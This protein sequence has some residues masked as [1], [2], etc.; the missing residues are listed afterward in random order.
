MSRDPGSDPVVADV[1]LDLADRR[2]GKVR[3]SY[4]LEGDRR[5]FITTDRLSAFDRIVAV[6]PW[7]GQ[8]L[9][10]LSAWWFNT[11][12]DIVDNHLLEVP[13]PRAMIVRSATPLPVEVVVR[14]AMT[15]ST[16]TSLWYQYSGGARQIYG[17][18]FPDGLIKNSLL[19]ELLITPTTKAPAGGHDEPLSTADVVDRG[20]V[21]A[22][23]WHRVTEAA[24]ALFT[25][26]EEIAARAGLILA[27]TKYEF[28]VD[29]EGHLLLIDEVHTPDSSRYW[30]RDTYL[31]RLHAGE[32]PE[33]LDKEPVRLALGAL[34]YRGEG[35]VPDLGAD[36]IASTSQRYIDAYERLTGEVFSPDGRDIEV[37]LAAVLD[38]SGGPR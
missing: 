29:S 2:E 28:G 20:L 37:R 22:D 17:Y 34:G 26:G 1:H 14:R 4:A 24:L 36:V 23:L 15:G 18:D 35:P 6:I 11:T 21:D 27:D 33:S 19:P 9:N 7:K 32:E 10:Q 12:R 16:T 31:D 25:R 13:D 30:A 3:V 8:V 38:P 5:L